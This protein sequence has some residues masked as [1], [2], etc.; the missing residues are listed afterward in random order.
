MKVVAV[1]GS[2]RAGG[3]RAP[4]LSRQSCPQSRVDLL[5]GLLLHVRGNVVLCTAEVRGS[6]PLRSTTDLQG[7]CAF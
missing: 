7:F 5:R 2:A 4:R 3:R 6:T 1:N